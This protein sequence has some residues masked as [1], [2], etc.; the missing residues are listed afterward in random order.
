MTTLKG[1]SAASFASVPVAPGQLP[2]IGHLHRLTRDLLNFLCTLSAVGDVVRVQAGPMPVYFVTTP[3]LVHQVLVVQRRSFEKGRLW[4]RQRPLLGASLPIVEGE[5]H[6]RQRK[7]A[8]P[9][10]QPAR[11]AR[12]VT[13]MDYHARALADSWRSGQVISV[14]R[15]MYN[16]T[17]PVVADALFSTNVDPVTIAAMHRLV[18]DLTEAMIPRAVTPKILDRV[19]IRSIRRFKTMSSQLRALIGGIVADRLAAN[20]GDQGDLLSMLTMARDSEAGDGLSADQ[21]RDEIISFMIGG[22]ETTSTTLTWLFYELARNPDIEGRVRQEVRA[23]IGDRP[24]SKDDVPRL[25]YTGRV[26]SEV[27]RLYAGSFLMLRAVGPVDLGGILIPPGTEIGV[28]PYGMH[29]DARLFTEPDQFD[30]DRWLPEHA[31]RVS[32]HAFIPFGAGQHKCIG[33]SFA[34]SE[35]ITTVAVIAA[36]WKLRLAVD[37]PI[38]TV[39]AALPKPRSLLMTVNA[40]DSEC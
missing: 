4:Q 20:T 40:V 21:L 25:E 39:I 14:D 22:T 6:R 15:E 30:P 23:V 3:E 18:P 9:A 37:S 26:L 13:R 5:D 34:W 28:S 24:I 31:G 38:C 32:R 7:L 35:M 27:A 8:Q 29:H 17:F 19:P 11:L 1:A 2:L 16:V 33:R 12:Y 10:F 36:R